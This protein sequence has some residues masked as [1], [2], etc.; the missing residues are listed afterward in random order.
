MIRETLNYGP[1]EVLVSQEIEIPSINGLKTVIPYSDQWKKLIV[2]VSG[3]LDSA[4]LLYLTAKTFKQIDSKTKIIP[5]SLEVPNKVK[6]LS[7]ARKVIQ[8]VRDTVQYEHLE[9]GIEVLM[10]EEKAH[11]D[12]KNKFFVDTLVRI[13]NEQGIDF[14]FNG[15][16]KNPPENVRKF[17][18]DDE[19]RELKRDNRSTIYNWKCSASPHSFNDKSGIV[20]L[21]KENKILESIAA[22]T[23]SCDINLDEKIKRNLPTPC[24]DCWWCHER[25]WGF[26]ANEIKDPSLALY[27][28]IQR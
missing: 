15:N 20:N 27:S 13:R 11:P 26:E 6:N 7:S 28:S 14:E 25:A 5:L 16:T 24:G 1:Q 4:L 2:Q 18:R 23:L 21:Y 17:F 3:G 19:F 8:A 22:H 12:H 10:P 9:K